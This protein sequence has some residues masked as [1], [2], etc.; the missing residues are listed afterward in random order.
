MV[1]SWPESVALHDAIIDRLASP[2]GRVRAEDAISTAAALCGESCIDATGEVDVKTLTILDPSKLFMAERQRTL[3]TIHPGQYVFS[4]AVNVFLSGDV[5]E[6]DAMPP[7]CVF[8]VLRDQLRGA[9]YARADF[10]EVAKIFSRLARTIDPTNPVMWGRVPL[11]VPKENRPSIMPLQ[12]AYELRGLV[13]TLAAKMHTGKAEDR[14]AR[15]A[16]CAYTLAK[17][18]ESVRDAIDPKVALTLAFETTNG[19]A[20]MAPVPDGAFDDAEDHRYSI[21]KG[22]IAFAP[23]PAPPPRP[24]LL[25]RLARLFGAA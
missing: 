4:A 1:Q 19:M 9:G 13:E 22:I 18:L 20:K 24:T 11:S 14:F 5:A 21:G 10:P 6:L 12:A 8:G 7:K 16:L 15:L 17:V 25:A 2:E 3:P 23:S